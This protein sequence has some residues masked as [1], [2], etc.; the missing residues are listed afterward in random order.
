MKHL[1]RSDTNKIFGGII[2]G[3][4]E[5]WGV[6]PTMLRLAFLAIAI[7]TGIVPGIIFYLVALI[8]VPKK[9]KE[10]HHES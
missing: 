10:A 1:Y 7:F 2:G 4:G 5:Y 9:R 6:D 3:L 8:I